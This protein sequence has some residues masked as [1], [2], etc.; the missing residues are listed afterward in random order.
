MNARLRVLH[1][2][3]LGRYGFAGGHPFG[4][5]RQGAFLAE[6]RGTGLDR[7]TDA[8]EPPLAAASDLLRFHTPEYVA[9]VKLMSKTGF[10]F[11]DHGDTPAFPGM[12]E[13]T[14]TVVGATLDACRAVSAGEAPRAFVPIAGLHHARRDAAAGFCV[15]NDIGVAIEWLRAV[16]GLHRIAYVDIDVHHGD[17]V[18]YSYEDDPDLIFADVHESGEYLYP[19]TGSASETGRGRAAGTKLNIPMPPGA[20]DAAFRAIWPRVEDYLRAAQPEFIIMQCGADSIAGDPLAHLAYQP[21]THGFAAARLRAIAD[22]CC[23]GRLVALGGGG[24]DRDNL[25]RAWCAVTRALA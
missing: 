3:T 11:L 15:F 2:D 7:T 22:D 10:G 8:H 5:D 25:A 14:S 24:Y 21:E 1:S 19:G 16:A 12:F 20:D 18:F 13:I 17:G 9:R 4:I 23:A 6:F